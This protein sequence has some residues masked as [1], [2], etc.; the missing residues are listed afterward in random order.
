MGR[1]APR[2]HNLY[3]GSRR[4]RKSQPAYLLDRMRVGKAHKIYG[5]PKVLLPGFHPVRYSC[6]KWRKNDLKNERL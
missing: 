5:R 4:T 2:C 1:E 6:R 3:D